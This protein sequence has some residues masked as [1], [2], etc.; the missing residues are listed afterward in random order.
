[1]APLL[2]PLFFLIRRS[3]SSLAAVSLDG[4]FISSSGTVSTSTMPSSF[5]SSP[6]GLLPPPSFGVFNDIFV[7]PSISSNALHFSPFASRAAHSSSS[8][9][10]AATASSFIRSGGKMGS[11]E[12]PPISS[13]PVLP[14]ISTSLSITS[15]A[16]ADEGSG[17][18]LR[19]TSSPTF[20]MMVWHIVSACW[21]LR[22]R[23]RSN[24]PSSSE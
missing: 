8:I 3:S 11:R 15:D 6:T 12:S 9:S 5:F 10:R 4:I 2:S 24:S 13:P 14:T 22:T 23:L 16:V 21:R 17:R 19:M 1:M 20:D 7:S 18:A